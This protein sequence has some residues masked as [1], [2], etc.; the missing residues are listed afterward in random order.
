MDAPGIGPGLRSDVAWT[1]S[2]VVYDRASRC[3][4]PTPDSTFIWS[5]R[6]RG[7]SRGSPSTSHRGCT[8]WS[9]GAASPS[10]AWPWPS[11][12]WRSTSTR[13]SGW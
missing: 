5:G 6:R 9:P 1:G 8:G 12:A 4:P 7:G 3:R 13:S 2:I 10:A 11:V